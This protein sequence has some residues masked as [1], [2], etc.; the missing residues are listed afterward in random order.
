[1][2]ERFANERKNIKPRL[3][4]TANSVGVQTIPAKTAEKSENHCKEGPK[5]ATVGKSGADICKFMT[6]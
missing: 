1:M 3:W 5:N 2:T 4:F 6:M